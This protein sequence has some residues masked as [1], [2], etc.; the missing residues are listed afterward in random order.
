[1][2]EEK[3]SSWMGPIFPGLAELH[4]RCSRFRVAR[5]YRA[6]RLKKTSQRHSDKMAGRLTSLVK[7]IRLS[8]RE[9][10]D[11]SDPLSILTFLSSFK[12]GCDNG[13]ISEGA[14]T[15]LLPYFLEG[16]PQREM[17]NYI[18]RRKSN[19]CEAVNNLLSTYASE[20]SLNTEYLKLHRFHQK[21][22]EDERAF[23]RRIRQ[24][25]D[26]MGTLY[27]TRQ[28]IEAYINGLSPPVRGLFT[29]LPSPPSAF[30]QVVV[31]C[32][33]LGAG[34]HAQPVTEI[35]RRSARMSLGPVP[36]RPTFMVEDVPDTSMNQIPPVS[37]VIN[38]SPDDYYRKPTETRRRGSCFLC[39]DSGH[40]TVDCPQLTDEQRQN[41]RDHRAAK[42]NAKVVTGTLPPPL[43]SGSSRYPHG[44]PNTALLVDNKELNSDSVGDMT[45]DGQESDEELLFCSEN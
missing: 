22:G 34:R 16:A 33:K 41:I 8:L 26:R 39:N 14:A 4:S 7:K 29:A 32:E 12:H 25:V 11:G 44:P 19:Y 38:D 13:G 18:S 5:S 3:Q 42:R 30:E 40:W 43:T 17:N 24:H 27:T 15:Y 9:S 23:G 45:Q 35:P 37:S 1:M 28:A 6:Y 21:S 20:D 36:P 2:E 10:F 31:L